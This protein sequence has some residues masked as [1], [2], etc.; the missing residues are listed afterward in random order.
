M[1][2]CVF[3]M[4]YFVSFLVLKSFCRGTENCLLFFLAGGGGGRGR[5]E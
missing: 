2:V 1:F 4:H 3:G 5:G